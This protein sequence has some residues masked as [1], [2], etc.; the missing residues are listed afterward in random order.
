MR[1]AFVVDAEHL[2]TEAEQRLG[3]LPAEPAQPDHH[4]VVA[5]GVLLRCQPTSGRSSG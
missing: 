5:G 3:D 2:V 1:L 4:D